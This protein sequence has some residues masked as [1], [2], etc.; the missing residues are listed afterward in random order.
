MPPTDLESAWTKHPGYVI[1]A[2]PVD[3]VGRAAVGS[4]VIAESDSCLVVAESNHVDRLYF[5]AEDVRW[6]HLTESD[7]R[8]ICPFKGQASYWSVT[9]DG[10]TLD[11]VAWSY[12][13]PFDEVAAIAGF[14]A[15]Y[16]DRLDITLTEQSDDGRRDLA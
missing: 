13:D 1:T 12:Q 15:F 7:H 14:V 10:T 9:V 4:V 6:E 16:A 8:T 11:E 5:P 3:G 2:T